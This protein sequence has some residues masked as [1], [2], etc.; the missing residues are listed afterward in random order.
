MHICISKLTTIGSD[1]GLSPGWH[2][3][4]IWTNDAVLLIWTLGTKFSE[5]IIDIHVFYQ[6]NA[7]QY[8][9][10]EMS[11]TLSQMPKYV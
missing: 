8:V 3:A 4:I 6:E 9:V 7:C 1:N 10:S 2:Q 5:M 11:A